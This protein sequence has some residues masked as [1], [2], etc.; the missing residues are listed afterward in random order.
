MN[1]RIDDV[2]VGIP[3]EA[4]AGQGLLP[5]LHQ[6][7]Q[8][9]E[10][11]LQTGRFQSRFPLMGSAQEQTRHELRDHGPSSKVPYFF[12]HYNII[13]GN[14][15]S[16]WPSGQRCRL[17]SVGTRV[18][19]QPKSKLFSK[20]STVSNYPLLVV[21]NLIISLNSKIFFKKISLNFKKKF[22]KNF[23]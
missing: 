8:P 16:R 23:I 21:F 4:A 11:R 12:N 17:A 13:L 15:M 22:R 18:R 19:S 10:G 7:D 14:K 2:S 5:A 3:A 20:Q 6:M 9:G 1:S